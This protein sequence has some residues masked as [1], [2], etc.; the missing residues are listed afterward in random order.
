MLESTGWA[1]RRCAKALAGLV[2]AG[3]SGWAA[4]GDK[5]KPVTPA[6]GAPG[7]IRYESC[8]R[9]V[10]PEE[11]FK[12]NHEGTVTL[13]FLIGADGRVKDSRMV[14]SSGYPA[15]DEAAR[16]GLVKCRFHPPMA[17]GKPVDAWTH[18]QYVWTTKANTERKREMSTSEMRYEAIGRYIYGAARFGGDMD[19]VERWIAD[20]LG[21]ARPQP[22]DSEAMNG[23]WT[24]FLDKYPTPEALQENHARFMEAL[25]NRPD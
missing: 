12:Q 10:Y 3:M 13:R 24:A 25:K 21:V 17:D 7:M 16:A 8:A 23:L 1:G 6:A 5:I 11:E 2:L 18:I 9:P 14:K 22:G 19:A 15:L 20:D 4:G